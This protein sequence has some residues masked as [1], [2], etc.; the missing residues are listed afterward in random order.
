MALNLSPIAHFQNAN[1][2]AAEEL[3]RAVRTTWMAAALDSALAEMAIG[4]ATSEHLIGARNF[5]RIFLNLSEPIALPPP[6]LPDKS[7]GQKP[8]EP[9]KE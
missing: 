6:P 4:N 5:I 8:A 7:L 2:L 3:H 9:K 1:K